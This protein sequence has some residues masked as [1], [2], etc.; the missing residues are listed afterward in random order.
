MPA[1]REN[2][3]LSHQNFY[4]SAIQ[5][6]IVE[7]REKPRALFMNEIVQGKSR[8]GSPVNVS[9]SRSKMVQN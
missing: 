9:N 1:L 3:A 7:S 4:V 2:Y 6:R 8:Q 5:S